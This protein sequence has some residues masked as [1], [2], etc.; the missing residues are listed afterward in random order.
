MKKEKKR[1]FSNAGCRV[2]LKYIRI[3]DD[4]GFPIMKVNEKFNLYDDIQSYKDD[5]TIERIIAR[6]GADISKIDTNKGVYID[7]SKIPDNYNDLMN[8]MNYIANDY[9]K[10]P[11]K[12][13]NAINNNYNL[14]YGLAMNGKVKDFIKYID[15][16]ENLKKTISNINFDFGSNKVND[17]NVEVKKD[18]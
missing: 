18:V 16:E 8:N 15:D 10:L 14:Y 2:A 5:N 9:S 1:I 4:N 11:I 6:L 12:Y 17:N 7:A 3:N 13:K